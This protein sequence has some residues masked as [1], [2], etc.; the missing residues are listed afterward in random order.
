MKQI[1]LK[2]ETGTYFCDE[3]MYL[4]AMEPRQ[5]NRLYRPPFGPHDLGLEPGGAVPTPMPETEADKME[6]ARADARL[7]LAR[8]NNLPRNGHE[9]MEEY[10]RHVAK[11]DRMVKA[12]LAYDLP[13]HW[14][15]R[16]IASVDHSSK[17]AKKLF[18]FWG[19][20]GENV[21]LE[22]LNKYDREYEQNLRHH[23][24]EL[25]E[26]Y[27]TERTTVREILARCRAEEE[28]ENAFWER[29]GTLPEQVRD[30]LAYEFAR[31]G[32]P[33]GHGVF[34]GFMR[35]GTKG[36]FWWHSWARTET[37]AGPAFGICPRCFAGRDPL[38]FFALGEVPAGLPLEGLREEEP[39]DWSTEACQ[40]I[41]DCSS[42]IRLE[43][44]R[45]RVF[46]FRLDKGGIRR[47]DIFYGGPGAE[48]QPDYVFTWPGGGEFQ[49]TLGEV[50][51]GKLVPLYR[52]DF[53]M[54]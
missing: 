50:V 10:L 38:L 54:K 29:C 25:W 31:Q 28:A 26:Q 11:L 21:P 8:Y 39:P 53:C 27:Q 45:G 18:G 36:V 34:H 13:S 22:Q 19:F 1:E 16:L 23:A 6:R 33:W 42:G 9:R 7:E 15:S 3:A 24:K 12:M 44:L 43:G 37:G 49:C 17:Q 2:N 14:G 5:A 52:D 30:Y 41:Q 35:M 40:I 47:M 32:P 20:T 51:D 46:L 4:S 48:E